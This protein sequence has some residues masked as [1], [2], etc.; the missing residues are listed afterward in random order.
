[1][2]INTNTVK[3]SSKCWHFW[4]QLQPCAKPGRGHV[5]D[6]PDWPLCGWSVLS[7]D[8]HLASR[9]RFPLR[10]LGEL[11]ELPNWLTWETHTKGQRHQRGSGLDFW[12]SACNLR[13]VLGSRQK[14][15]PFAKLREDF[16]RKHKSQGQF[17]FRKSLHQRFHE[18]LHAKWEAVL[19]QARS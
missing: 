16:P 12:P 14:A 3:T 1:V 4:K 5:G 18:P 2:I 11:L 9:M 8:A 19:G 7:T 13:L 15:H 17:R 10:T 6:S